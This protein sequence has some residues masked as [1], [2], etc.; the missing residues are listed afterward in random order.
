[1]RACGP[2]HA[3]AGAVGARNALTT[4]SPARR[5]KWGAVT[6]GLRSVSRMAAITCARIRCM[7]WGRKPSSS[8]F[9]VLI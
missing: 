6:I 5:A 3:S 4:F 9:T 8:G 7:G 2:V 1:M